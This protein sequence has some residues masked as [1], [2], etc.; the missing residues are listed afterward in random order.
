MLS[1]LPSPVDEFHW[2]NSQ[3][4]GDD[5]ICV[6]SSVHDLHKAISITTNKYQSTLMEK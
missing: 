6:V 2:F 4:R 1:Y 3:H 5:V